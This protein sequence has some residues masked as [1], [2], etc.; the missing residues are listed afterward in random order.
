MQNLLQNKYHIYVL[1]SSE[2]PENIRYVG[3]TS[4]KVSERFSQHKYC[5]NHSEKRGLPVHK[6]MYSKYK[7][8][9]T[10]LVKEIDSCDESEWE[11]REQYWIKFYKDQGYNLM[12]LDKGGKGVITKEKRSK[13]SIE[14]SIEGHEKPIVALNKDGS[15]YKRFDSATKAA[16]F[17]NLKS[18]TAITNAVSGWSKSCY[19][20]LWVYECDYD[21]SKI[22]NYK[23]DFNTTPVYQFDL[24]GNLIKYW[25]K[26]T[27]LDKLPG[28]TSQSVKHAIKNKKAY[29]DFYWSFENKIDT[30]QYSN[31]F[32]YKITND[33]ECKYFKFQKE[34]AN[35]LNISNSVICTKL[36]EGE[37]VKGYTITKI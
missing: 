29:H 8:G 4:K 10:I 35:Y 17:F 28:Y 19:G 9:G 16:K 18:K 11:N 14:R 31:L 3:V 37:K 25:Y 12:N 21:P 34:I 7:D 15:F 1:S 26:I 20:Y 27:Q 36:K 2:D 33:T 13:N 5:A 24:Q 22:Y 6:W 23:P 30:S 32:K